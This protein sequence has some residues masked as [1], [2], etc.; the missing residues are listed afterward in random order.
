MQA[1]EE[2]SVI[3]RRPL[4]DAAISSHGLRLLRLIGIS[5]A[6]TA[7]MPK[8]QNIRSLRVGRKRKR[9]GEE[10]RALRGSA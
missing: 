8:N 10:R 1:S 6:M 7:R 3:A 5:L 9:K 2:G 4:A